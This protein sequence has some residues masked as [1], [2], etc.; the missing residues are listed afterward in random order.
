VLSIGK[1]INTK[2]NKMRDLYQEIQEFYLL[3]EGLSKEPS[4]PIETRKVKTTGNLYH[5]LNSTVHTQYNAAQSHETDK[6]AP[7]Q[8]DISHHVSW[9]NLIDRNNMNNTQ[10][11]HT[12]HDAL[13]LHNDYVK[14]HTNIGDLVTNHPATKADKTE[15]N[16]RE[17]IYR[18]VAGFG[19]LAKDGRTQYGIVKQHPDVHPEEHLRGQKYLH[20]LEDHE[21]KSYQEKNRLINDMK[22][23]NTPEKREEGIAK[24]KKGQEKWEEKRMLSGRLSLASLQRKPGSD[25]NH[26]ERGQRLINTKRSILGGYLHQENF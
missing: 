10:K 4:S 12:L 15:R 7:G 2:F 13:H 18:K 21:I 19:A 17:E 25:K 16:R 11:K 26:L 9:N 22:R 24:I 20:P 1:I 6:I 14:N 5:S 23:N 8:S 3:G